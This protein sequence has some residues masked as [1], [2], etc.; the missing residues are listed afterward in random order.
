MR[1]IRLGRHAEWRRR[2]ARH[3][4]PGRPRGR[5]GARSGTGAELWG[6]ELGGACG[7]R[8]GRAGDRAKARNDIGVR[9]DRGIRYVADD[10]RTWPRCVTATVGERHPALGQ[11]ALYHVV[12]GLPVGRRAGRRNTG[13]ATSIAKLIATA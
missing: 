12:D 5:E 1:R 9:D 13:A 2:T 7:W 10:S 3:P 4:Q 6:A 8:D 11:S